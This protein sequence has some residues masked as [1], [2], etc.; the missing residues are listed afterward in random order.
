MVLARYSSTGR[1]IEGGVMRLRRRH[2]RLED[3]QPQFF[4]KRAHLDHK[5]AGERERT[6]SSRLSRS[7]GGRSAAITT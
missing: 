5:A 2:P 1:Y 4:A 7:D 6:R 3:F